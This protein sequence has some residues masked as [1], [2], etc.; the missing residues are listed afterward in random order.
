MVATEFDAEA[1][2]GEVVVV[3]LGEARHRHAADDAGA[4]DVDGEAA[5]VGGVVGVGEGVFFAEGGVALLEAEAD[6]VG[7]AVEAGDDVRFALDPAGVVGR[8]AGEGGVEERLVR[9]AE[10][11]DID[12]DGELAGEGEFAEGE[13]EAPGGVVVEVGEVELGFL[14]DDRGEI[15]G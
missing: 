4:G 14:V 7:A 12:D 1:F 8:G 15:F 9:S 5:A 2:D 11:A 6:L 10:A 13:A 3:A